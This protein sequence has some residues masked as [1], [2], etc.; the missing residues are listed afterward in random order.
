MFFLL[1]LLTG[2]SSLA[3]E[4]ILINFESGEIGK[5]PTGWATNDKKNAQKIYSIQSEA[6][7]KFLHAD[8][9]G[10]WAQIGL[11]KKWALK[12]FPI[13]QWQWR[14]VLF[15]TNSNERE[16]S[17]NDSVLGVYVV[18]GHWPF[19]KVIKYIWSDTLPVGAS[20]LSPYSRETKIFVLES[21]RLNA[22]RWIREKRDVWQDYKQLYG[23]EEI[24]PI[25]T[26]MAVLTDSDNTNS[27]AIGDYADF[28]ISSSN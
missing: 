20:F 17:R 7:K 27:H 15:P 24:N 14:A 22:G 11:E 9:K 18:F 21:G 6:D 2:H 1:L 13:L 12:E 26:G 28:Q 5:F 25:A 16:K 8:S 3:R 19:I 10:S 4:P 23:E